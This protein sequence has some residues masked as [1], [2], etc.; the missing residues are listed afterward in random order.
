MNQNYHRY[1]TFSLGKHLGFGI[2]CNEVRTNPILLRM[3]C[4]YAPIMKTVNKISTMAWVVQGKFPSLLFPIEVKNIHKAMH[5]SDSGV[6]DSQG[7][8]LYMCVDF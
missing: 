8:Y 3:L 7:R 6:Y 1:I 4:V 5:G 2:W